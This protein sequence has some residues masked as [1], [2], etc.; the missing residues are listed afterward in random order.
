[1]LVVSTLSLIVSAAAGAAWSPVMAAV[2]TVAIFVSIDRR[3]ERSS[4]LPVP[5]PTHGGS[6]VVIDN[7]HDRFAEAVSDA[8]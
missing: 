2:S 4:A 6:W 3:K 5:Q 1:M 8:P 7:V